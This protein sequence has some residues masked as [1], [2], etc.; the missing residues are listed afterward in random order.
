MSGVFALPFFFSPYSPFLVFF[1]L[2]VHRNVQIGRRRPRGP[3][4]AAPVPRR[5]R[6]SREKSS[7]LRCPAKKRR[8]CEGDSLGRLQE[9]PGEGQAAGTRGRRRRSEGLPLPGED[10]GGGFLKRSSIFRPNEIMSAGRIARLRQGRAGGGVAGGGEGA[11]GEEPDLQGRRAC[12]SRCPGGEEDGG[13]EGGAADQLPCANCFL[14]APVSPWA[15]RL[16]S[17]H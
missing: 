9:P 16:V 11:E 13:E 14:R 6:D 1:D 3:G 8:T 2:C 7:S 5:P 15:S 12:R 17:L 10:G 4:E